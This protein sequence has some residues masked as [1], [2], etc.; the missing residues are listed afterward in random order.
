MVKET[1][2]RKEEQSFEEIHKR[3]KQAIPKEST[4]VHNTYKPESI[5]CQH[6][7]TSIPILRRIIEVYLVWSIRLF[8]NIPTPAMMALQADGEP[9]WKF[10]SSFKGMESLEA[11]IKVEDG[12]EGAKPV[13]QN[14]ATQ[15]RRNNT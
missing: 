15:A 1:G 4:H 8:L 13:Q 2:K 5:I 12:Q 10:D 7:Q 14:Q 11:R 9:S 3:Q 6:Q